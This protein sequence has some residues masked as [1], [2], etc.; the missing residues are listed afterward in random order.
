MSEKINFSVRELNIKDIEDMKDSFL[1]TLSNLKETGDLDEQKAKN[2]LSKIISQDGHVLV[3]IDKQHGIVGATTLLVEQKFIRQGA[4]AG[5]IEDVATRKGFEG[6]G[7]AK[8]I[9]QESIKLAKDLGCYKIV[10]DCDDELVPFYQKLGFSEDG[11]FMRLY[12]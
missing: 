9:L 12:L 7:I 4:K 5:H 11:R 10:L 6:K 2:I 8:T 1:T 3:A